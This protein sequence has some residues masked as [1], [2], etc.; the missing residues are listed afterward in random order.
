MQTQKMYALEDLVLDVVSRQ[1]IYK[2]ARESFMDAKKKLAAVREFDETFVWCE[3]CGHKHY[4][5]TRTKHST[6]RIPKECLLES[7]H[8]WQHID[9]EEGEPDEVGIPCVSL[10]RCIVCGREKREVGGWM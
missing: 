2:R 1:R 8:C 7:D 3:R 10:S 5:W 9:T 6:Q 4:A